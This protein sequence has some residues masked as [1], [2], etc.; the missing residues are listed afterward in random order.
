MSSK[1]NQLGEAKVNVNI[2]KKFVDATISFCEEQRHFN[3]SLLEAVEAF[4]D[5]VQLHVQSQT[6]L[7]KDLHQR[8]AEIEEVLHIKP[9]NKIN[10]NR[11]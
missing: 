6:Q 1:K 2:S 8:I 7:I 4:R 3:G 5:G 10:W 9:N 11:Q